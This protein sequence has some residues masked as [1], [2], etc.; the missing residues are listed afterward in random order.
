MS[1]LQKKPQINEPKSYYTI[2]LHKTVLIVGLGN[3]E[4]KYDLTRHN[5]GF[6]CLDDF[7]SNTEEMGNWVLKKDLKA[8]V[9]EGNLGG[10]RIIAIKPTTYMNLS[11][12]AVNLVVRFYNIL[13][14]DIAVIH[15]DLDIDFG[16][17]RLRSGGSSGGHN[18]IK[19][20]SKS[21]GENYGRIRV[22]IGPKEPEQMSTEDFVLAKFNKDEKKELPNLSKE[23]LSIISEYI[24][25]GSLNTETRSFII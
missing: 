4:P 18:G 3:P 19:S 17:I 6:L 22:G 7:V 15:D 13:P 12:E 2:G 1:W 5:I 14:D 25:G 20:V 11:G 9:S 24:Y 10:N 8:V 21:I 16:Q 23:V